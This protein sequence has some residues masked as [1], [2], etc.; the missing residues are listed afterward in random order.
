M[1]DDNRRTHV[2]VAGRTYKEKPRVSIEIGEITDLDFPYYK[3]HPKLAKRAKNGQFERLKAI[4]E[5]ERE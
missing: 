1:N 2:Y 3:V 5:R 4:W